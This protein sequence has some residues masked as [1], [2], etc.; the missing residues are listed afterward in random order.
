MRS[1][2]HK[3]L[4]NAISVLSSLIAANFDCS[5]LHIVKNYNLS[6]PDADKLC[7]RRKQKVIVII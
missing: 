6:A 2:S 4:I 5:P 1:Q 7:T 3:S